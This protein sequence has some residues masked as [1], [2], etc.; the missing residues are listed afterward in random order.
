LSPPLL[1][2]E[3][4][5]VEIDAAGRR[6]R[7][8]EEVSLRVERGRA[9]GLLGESGS[10]K[11]VT[12][13]ALL[14]LFPGRGAEVTGSVRLEGR[15][16]L[17][18]P[19]RALREVRGAQAAMIFQDPAAALDPR[20]TVGAHLTEAL[21]LHQRVPAA[22]ARRRSVEL[23]AQV[24]LGD[25]AARLS[26]YPHQLSGGLRQRVMI[27][28]ALAAAPRLL[29]ADEPT[30]ALDVTIQAQ[31][32]EL[33]GR[34]QGERELGVLL[35]THDLGLVAEQCQDVVVLYAGQVVERGEVAQVLGAPLH[36]YT[37][38]LLAS[39]PVPGARLERL[40]E[41]PGV[42]P[43]LAK[44]AAG[45][46]FRDRCSGAQARCAAEAPPLVSLGERAHRCFFP[47]AGAGPEARS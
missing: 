39:S 45:C 3:G 36:P 33:L 34:L 13:L 14:G 17:G 35:I 9:L 10:G 28:I 44:L 12:A 23:L 19:E 21:Q 40:Q 7:L 16:L 32:M 38:G 6:L 2:V 24:G 30:T 27:A 4:L 11:S 18:L 29:I 47:L 41:I 43:D 8:V 5:C 46:R 42:V 15:E 37:A 25:P 20:W 31:V 1:E 26:A 22:E